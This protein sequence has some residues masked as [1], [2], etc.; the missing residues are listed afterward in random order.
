MPQASRSIKLRLIVAAL[1]TISMAM[2]T[3]GWALLLL[4]EHHLERRVVVKLETDLRQLIAGLSIGAG[5]SITLQRK[6]ADPLY[7]QPLSG[8][9]WQVRSAGTVIERSRSLW[10]E[11]LVLPKDD[12]ASGIHEHVIAGP[13]GQPLI[14]V[15]RAVQTNREGESA[16]LRFVVAQDRADTIAAARSFGRELAIMLSLLGA[17]LLIAFYVAVGIGLS[18]L[19]RLRSSLA[20]LRSAKISRLSGAYPAEVALLVQDLNTLLDARDSVAERSRRRAADLAHGLKTP[21]TAMSAIA[22]ELDADGNKEIA[23]ELRSS[24]ASM[25]RHVERELALSRSTSVVSTKAAT[26]LEPVVTGLVRSLQRL[27][28]GR[29]LVWE[30]EI[31]D[32]LSLGVDQTALAEIIGGLLDNAR[33]WARHR[34]SVQARRSGDHISIVVADDGPGVNENELANLTARGSRLDEKKPGTGLGL[35]IAADIV[36]ALSGHL[37]LTNGHAGGLIAHVLLPLRSQGS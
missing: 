17:L 2:A 12:P 25:L 22:E 8:S 32:E 29:E 16:S 13:R 36:E 33:K 6:P 23:R 30:V 1:F 28:R 3:A 26:P 9:Y 10:D 35:A 20:E 15:E 14:A 37:Q 24:A 7:A 4:F 21:I 19:R 5:G 34:V 31:D 18:P 11:T 27:P